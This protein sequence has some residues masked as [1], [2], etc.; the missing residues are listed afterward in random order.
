MRDQIIRIGLFV[1]LAS[2]ISDLILPANSGFL[3]TAVL[4]FGIYFIQKRYKN[5]NEGLMSYGKGLGLGV[6]VALISGVVLGIYTYVNLILE[7]GLADELLNEIAYSLEESGVGG[8][9]FD[10]VMGFYEKLFTPFWLGLFAIIGNVFFGFII[11]LLISLLNSRA[12]NS[13]PE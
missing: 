13:Y 4:V 6:M 11:S 7:P 12:G 3:Q 5:Q 8:D 9:M 2:I 10:K 1:G